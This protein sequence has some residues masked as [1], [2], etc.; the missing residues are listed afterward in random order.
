RHLRQRRVKA[1]GAWHSWDRRSWNYKG[2]FFT[3]PL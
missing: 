2:S 1:S 3:S